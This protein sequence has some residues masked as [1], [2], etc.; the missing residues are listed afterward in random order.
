MLTTKL[1]WQVPVRFF[2]A[3]IPRSLQVIANTGVMPLANKWFLNG[4]YTLD[5][6]LA[7]LG[8]AIIIG[9]IMANPIF[10]ALANVAESS[11]TS[12]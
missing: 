9:M 7:I 12:R 8:F 1:S 10:G 11:F 4:V 3:L 6:D 2:L 5:R